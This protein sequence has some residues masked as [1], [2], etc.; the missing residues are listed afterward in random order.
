MLNCPTGCLFVR[1]KL[2]CIHH[3]SK[4]KV[5]PYSRFLISCIELHVNVI[6]EEDSID[7]YSMENIDERPE[8][9]FQVK[10]IYLSVNC[11]FIILELVL[12]HEE[13]QIEM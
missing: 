8:E 11:E 12:W 2:T 6:M 1:Q 13:G 10:S 5:V 7:P 3:S 9:C 4:I